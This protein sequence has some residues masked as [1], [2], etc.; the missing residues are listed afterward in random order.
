MRCALLFAVVTVL[1]ASQLSGAPPVRGDWT[2]VE[3]AIADDQPKTAAAELKLI[4]NSAIENQRY[5]EAIKA[6]CRQIQL[7][8]DPTGDH[9]ERRISE[10]D[11]VLPKMPAPMQPIL[12]IVVANW[13]AD[14]RMWHELQDPW[15]RSRLDRDAGGSKPDDITQWSAEQLI[16]AMSDHIDRA[17]QD[18][19]RLQR[20]PISQ[21]AAVLQT[22]SLPY[23]YRP[24]LYDVVMHQAI[25]CYLEQGTS[26]GFFTSHNERR[27]VNY[28]AALASNREFLAWKPASELQASPFQKALRAYQLLLKFH[29]DDRDRSAWLDAELN[30]ILFA[31]RWLTSPNIE[32]RFSE[33]LERFAKQYSDHPIVVRAI[34]EQAA[35]HYNSG[36]FAKARESAL[37]GKNLFPGSVGNQ[38]CRA[39]IRRVE[40]KEL[41]VKVS[42]LQHS[43]RPTIHITYRNVGHIYLRVVPLTYDECRR[44]DTFDT[45]LIRK[46]RRRELLEREPFHEWTVKLPA[47]KEYRRRSHEITI[48]VDLPS[49]PYVVL[50]GLREDLRKRKSLAVAGYFWRTN[51]AIV[52]LSR[53]NGVREYMLVDAETGDPIVGAQVSVDRLQKGDSPR[54]SKRIGRRTTDRL[55]RFTIAE[56]HGSQTLFDITYGDDRMLHSTS[57]WRVS[58]TEDVRQGQ[59]I[60]IYTD[61][62]VYRPGQEIRYKGIFFAYDLDD[63]EHQVRPG[64]LVTVVFT[65]ALGQELA[66]RSH[67]TNRYGSFHGSFRAPSRR[68]LGR[69]SIRTLFDPFGFD[70]FGSEPLGSASFRV[71]EYK[72]AKIQVELERYRGAAQVGEPV[73]VT[74]RAVSYTSAALDNAVVRWRVSRDLSV[75]SEW[76]DEDSRYDQVLAWER[77]RI[78]GQVGTDAQGRY[79]ITFPTSLP[80]DLPADVPVTISFRID[81]DLV[82]ASGEAATATRRVEIGRPGLSVDIDLDRYPTVQRPISC[83][84]AVSTLNGVSPGEVNGTLSVYEIVQPKTIAESIEPIELW[85]DYHAPSWNA[86]GFPD[87]KRWPNGRRVVTVPVKTDSEGKAS[88]ELSLAA[89]L[90]RVEYEMQGAGG[91]VVRETRS[92]IVL[93]PLAQEFP[94]RLPIYLAAERETVRVGETLAVVWGSGFESARAFVEIEQRGRILQQFWT[95]PDRTQQQFRFQITNALRGGFVLRVWVVRNGRLYPL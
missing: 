34:Y 15:Q 65:D 91:N 73:T 51:L 69:M 75:P 55:G 48:P 86:P 1:S 14:S 81:V 25:E 72:R 38:W 36:D 56:P 93:D 9:A 92:L 22:G 47:T 44:D 10:L 33:A 31:G 54:V 83:S 60:K 3:Q 77:R 70:P 59:R 40:E 74:G 17:L 62:A 16:E 32:T 35:M 94:V 8:F 57:G 58:K 46:L 49:G 50:A 45:D 42:R 19:E 87:T 67:H 11:R 53:R 29:Q 78:S 52:S 84:I 13:Y 24:T 43:K 41:D 79:S 90:F 63:G 23:A 80:F 85:Q 4:L 21:Y 6:L 88:A 12:H 76:I 37:R 7:E 27:L 26:L 68:L 20:I 89:G 64:T 39:L 82:D 71:E 18:A 61:R 28:P 5:A 30:R 2:R 95:D 66:R